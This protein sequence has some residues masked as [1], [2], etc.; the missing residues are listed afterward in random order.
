MSKHKEPKV[1]Y[2]P[3]QGKHTDAPERDYTLV[4][5]MKLG[6]IANILFVAFIIICLIYYYSLAKFGK[7]VI[8][9]EIVAY[10]TD[11]MGFA[12]FTLGV[13]WMDKLMRARTL[14]KV[15]MPLYITMEVVL[16]LLEFNLLPFIPYNG[17][18]LSS[19]IIH[20]LLSAGISLTMLQLNPQS[21]RVQVI[22][23]VTTMIILA[24]MLPG[25]A[26]YR[27]YASV[28]INAF[29]YI[30]FFAA[31]RR[32]LVNE[33]VEIDCHGDRAKVTSF[34]TTM[35]SDEPLLQEPPEKKRRTVAQ[36]AKDA[37]ARLTAEERPVLTDSSEHFEYEFGADDD[38][39][40]EY[41]DDE[42]DD[43]EYDDDEYDDSDGDGGGVKQ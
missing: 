14:L 9:F 10:G 32:Q 40:D 5:C 25:I 24:G 39:D 21:R 27:V 7:Y 37:A 42:Y 12:L 11:A 1:T 26:G 22:V 23:A 4:D 41:D 33:E 3:E 19:L 2:T 35:F 6:L 34:S 20:A 28:L 29:A 17:L 16:M 15:L 36:L 30:F 38:D 31:M 18:A 13:V 43:E 8:P